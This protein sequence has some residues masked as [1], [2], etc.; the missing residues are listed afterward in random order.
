MTVLS[1]LQIRQSPANASINVARRAR[2]MRWPI[3][4]QMS[5]GSVDALPPLLLDAAE[6][7]Y[8]HSNYFV[9]AHY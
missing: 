6:R 7:V 8:C 9:H 2:C 3:Q 1:A 5:V 4:L